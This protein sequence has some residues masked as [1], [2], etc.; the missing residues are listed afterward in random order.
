[1]E[2]TL[3]DMIVL[4]EV[5]DAGSFSQAADRLGRTKSSVSQSVTRLETS[6]DLRLIQRTTRRLALTEP[7]QRFY[8]HCAAI[9]EIYGVA[10]EE[11]RAKSES[12]SGRLVLTAPHA[13][14]AAFVRPAVESF[15]S[16]HP[17]LEISFVTED[18]QLNLVD[19][20]IDLAIRVGMPGDQSLKVTKL[21]AFRDLLC[22]HRDLVSKMGGP[23]KTLAELAAW[24][25]IANEWQGAEVEY[26]RPGQRAVRV[27]PRIRCNAF[28]DVLGFL[29]AGQGVALLP[30]IAIQEELSSGRIVVLLP[31]EDAPSSEIFAAH[32]FG[33]FPPRRVTAFVSHLRKTLSSTSA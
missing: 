6:L 25:H 18:W 20:A 10:L 29:R 16:A 9:R 15:L 30:D 19:Y 26:R 27:S 4:A 7:G 12:L 31:Q 17:G 33:G 13:L 1:M 32:A 3:K 5:V 2:P 23:P 28:N 11:A 22:A 24:D 14:S 21:G 8:R